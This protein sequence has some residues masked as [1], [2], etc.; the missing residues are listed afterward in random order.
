MAK[1]F[2]NA[3]L[4][5]AYIEIQIEY[6]YQW[7]EAIYKQPDV[8]KVSEFTSNEYYAMIKALRYLKD[9]ISTFETKDKE[10]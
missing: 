10:S 3:D 8:E 5:D 9:S 6:Y 2:Y 7:T 4:I 1:R